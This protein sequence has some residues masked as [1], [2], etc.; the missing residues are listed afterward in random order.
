LK[1]T[2]SNL[3]KSPFVNIRKLA[4]FVG[5]VVSLVPVVGS[6]SSLLTRFFQMTIAN[7]DSYDAI[8]ELSPEINFE[9][10][11]WFSHILK[12]NTRSCIVS[13]PPVA[14]SIFG[15]ASAT[16]CG[17]FIVNSGLVAARSFTVEERQAH[18]TCRELENVHFTLK[19]FLP[20]LEDR[21]VKFFVDNESSMR[22]ISNGSMKLSCHQFALEIFKT[23]FENSISLNMEWVPRGENKVADAIL[24]LSEV[25]DTD[26]WGISDEF[27]KLLNS[28]FGP[29]PV[30]C[31]A[32]FYNS[33][34]SKFY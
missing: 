2:I 10:E 17:S 3:E 12:L 9:L 30:D 13:K 15:N 19:A 27:F 23:Y 26:D 14:L 21:C 11:F 5:Q 7:S 16:G 4:S 31:F 1:E 32:N 25:I 33:K 24:R 29:F 6:V 28:R 22:I 20:H 34:L 18:S 8:S